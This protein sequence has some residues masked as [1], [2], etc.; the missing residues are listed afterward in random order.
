[1][2]K[3]VLL[4]AALLLTGCAQPV[5]GPVLLQGERPQ[6]LVTFYPLH[7]FAAAVGGDRIALSTLIPPGTEAHD[8]EP[9]AQD[10]KRLAAAHLFIYNGGG[11]EPWVKKALRSVR[12]Q[13]VVETTAGL[14]L[15]KG[16][17]QHSHGGDDPHVWLDPV[18]AQHQVDLI[19]R[20]LADLDPAGREVYLLNAA[21]YKERL[22]GLDAEFRAGLAD[23]RRRQIVTAHAAYGY[24][25]RRYEIAQIPLMGLS[26]EAEPKPRDLARIVKLVREAQISYIFFESAVSERVADV[27]ARETGARTLVL[28]PL[29]GPVPGLDFIGAMQQNLA[30]LRLALACN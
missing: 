30:H 5:E 26:A 15:Q 25:T 8:Y 27:I 9:G 17:D 4:L 2:K 23:C 7:Q 12:P 16:M 1:V 11:F 10:M 3:A 6:V 18:L 13:A 21:A 22:A 20:A 28:H 29:E 24:L 14:A 19:A